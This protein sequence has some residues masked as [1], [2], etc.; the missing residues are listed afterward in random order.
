ML[1]QLTVALALEVSRQVSLKR[2]HLNHL[3]ERRRTYFQFYLLTMSRLF[4]ESKL[5]PENLIIYYR[6]RT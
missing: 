4:I 5:S 1:V 2:V 3:F 6:P